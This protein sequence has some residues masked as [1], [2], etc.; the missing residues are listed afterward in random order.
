MLNGCQCD[1][2]V[3]TKHYQNFRDAEHRG[4][5][6]LGGG[7]NLWFTQ[8]LMFLFSKVTRVYSSEMIAVLIFFYIPFKVCVA[9]Y[10]ATRYFEWMS[11]LKFCCTATNLIK[12]IGWSNLLLRTCIFLF[13]CWKVKEQS[14]LFFSDYLIWNYRGCVY[15]HFSSKFRI[16]WSFILEMCFVST[17]SKGQVFRKVTIEK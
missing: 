7:Y 8:L 16:T 6:A 15:R 2:C 1:G 3:V 9:V 13:S 5:V 17:V 14:N 4:C 11:K 10:S 12:S